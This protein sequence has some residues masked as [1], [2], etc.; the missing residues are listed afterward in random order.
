MYRIY[1]ATTKN[2]FACLAVLLL[3]GFGGACS[4]EEQQNKEEGPARLLSYAKNNYAFCGGELYSLGELG[5][6][7]E[8]IVPVQNE[9]KIG[10]YEGFLSIWP[11]L[12]RGLFFDKENGRISANLSVTQAHQG[13]HKEHS[14]YYIRDVSRDRSLLTSLTIAVL[15]LTQIGHSPPTLELET[16]ASYN[17]APLYRGFPYEREKFPDYPH[18]FSITP[19]LLP[20]GLSFDT[21]TGVISGALQN[22]FDGEYSVSLNS[23]L[24]P[25]HSYDLRIR[26]ALVNQPPV[27]H[28]DKIVLPLNPE[29]YPTPAD[30]EAEEALN[31][32]F[33]SALTNVDSRFP[34]EYSDAEGDPVEFRLVSQTNNNPHAY[35][36]VRYSYDPVTMQNIPQVDPDTDCFPLSFGVS[37]KGE[38]YLHYPHVSEKKE[39]YP[40]FALQSETLRI[41]ATDLLTGK[42][43]E[44]DIVVE[45]APRS[46]ECGSYS[47]GSIEEYK[48]LYQQ[49][50]PALTQNTHDPSLLAS[51]PRLVQ[52]SSNYRLIFREEFNGTGLESL[53]PSVLRIDINGNN[54]PTTVE[55][56][57]YAFTQNDSLTGCPNKLS[58][59]GRFE[60]K[61]GYLEVKVKLPLKQSDAYSNFA[62]VLY[63]RYHER[64]SSA[65]AAN[66]AILRHYDL[67]GFNQ[68]Q[69]YYTYRG[70]ELDL[71]EYVSGSTRRL[72]YHTYSN[73]YSDTRYIPTL[74]AMPKRYDT[75]LAFCSDIGPRFIPYLLGDSRCASRYSSLSYDNSLLTVTFGL[76]WTPEGYRRFHKVEGIHDS[77]VIQPTSRMQFGLKDLSPAQQTGGDWILEKASSI[78]YYRGWIDNNEAAQSF[79]ESLFHYQDE[80]MDND[81]TADDPDPESLLLQYNIFHT[82][83][84]IEVNNWGDS[85]IS[86]NKMYIDYIRVFQP[87][88]KY[89]S[90]TPVYQ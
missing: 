11:P 78:T 57:Y 36:R 49:E 74:H 42:S 68:A 22:A 58:T 14:I 61:Y 37:P 25:S 12:P 54:C 26:S 20:E 4:S 70:G 3:G 38:V 73:Y 77:F 30:A 72:H 76:E 59:Q 62:F 39:Y 48:C 31:Q 18:S 69:D 75:G 33:D 52:S 28:T 46:D 79:L 15:D 35:C 23:P 65:D 83:A 2:I 88:D 41:A 5:E 40:A 55:N 81:G 13:E 6:E 66:Y 47:A 45:S 51:L 80:D 29:V 1:R 56:G 90:M 71:F 43:A 10:P 89:S 63:S 27:I 53:E 16:G 19:L 67:L 82:P 9:L 84:Y 21:V 24:C 34:L 17:I 50:L 8:E 87:V 64:K 44:K 32:R 85:R 60:Y 7:Q 86:T